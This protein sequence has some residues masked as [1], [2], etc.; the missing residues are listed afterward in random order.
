[1]S[2]EISIEKNVSG[3]D[4]SL[5]KF[6]SPIS[7]SISIEISKDDENRIVAN[8]IVTKLY[9]KKILAENIILNNLYNI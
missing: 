2:I 3:R 9:K 5:K 6:S 1:M 8:K 7:K 4:N